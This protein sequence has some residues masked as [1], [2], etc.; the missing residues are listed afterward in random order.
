MYM[1]AGEEQQRTPPDST[2]SEETTP[3]LSVDEQ[4]TSGS[5][6]SEETTPDLSVGEQHTSDSTINEDTTPDL[7]VGEQPWGLSRVSY[8]L[9]RFSTSILQYSNAADLQSIV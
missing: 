4:H 8:I 2:V 7:S 5:T 6:V 9:C 1:S 3:D